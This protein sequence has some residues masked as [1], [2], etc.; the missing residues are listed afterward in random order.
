[1][2]YL[3]E[4]VIT[5]GA[6]ACIL[7]Y[8]AAYSSHGDQISEDQKENS[9]K[10]FPFVLIDW[11]IPAIAAG[12]LVVDQPY[13]LSDSTPYFAQHPREVMALLAA[14]VVAIAFGVFFAHAEEPPRPAVVVAAWL[15]A[16]AV[17]LCSLF[18]VALAG[19]LPQLFST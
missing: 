2:L 5:L 15:Y 16:A 9:K 14:A 8:V 18:A 12:I 19:G 13:I 17:A 1:M 4:V 6:F 3:C 10:Q 11:G 7:V